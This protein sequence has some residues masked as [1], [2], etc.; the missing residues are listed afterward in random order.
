MYMLI[1][2]YHKSPRL[3]ESG[4]WPLGDPEINL[5]TMEICIKAGD[6]HF[7]RSLLVVKHLFYDNCRKHVGDG[8]NTRFWEDLW[9][10]D[11]PLK[12]AYPRLFDLWFNKT[13]LLLRH[14]A[15]GWV[16]SPL[17]EPSLWG[18]K[19]LWVSYKYRCDEILSFLIKKE[20]SE[21][22][23]SIETGLSLLISM[24]EIDQWSS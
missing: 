4:R 2:V 8:C 22:C 24:I 3:A 7:W 11:K 21:Q 19:N 1:R 16:T 15:W 14:S 20:E 12:V 18:S 6:S 10:D 17:E 5:P 23:S 13:C 9:H